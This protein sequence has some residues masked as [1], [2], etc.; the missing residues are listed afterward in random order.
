MYTDLA[1]PAT[2][3]RLAELLRHRHLDVFCLNDTDC[4][5][6]TASLQAEL[7]GEFLPAFF[8]FRSPFELVEPRSA[9]G[10]PAA[11]PSERPA[12]VDPLAAGVPVQPERSTSAQSAA[13]PAPA[14][15]APGLQTAD[16][17]I[18]AGPAHPAKPAAAPTDA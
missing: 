7:L 10:A 11:K 13:D 6:A 12:S 9:T 8:P 17:P 5:P 18:Q 16:L 14:P 15:A 4:D 3:F 1:D 2:P